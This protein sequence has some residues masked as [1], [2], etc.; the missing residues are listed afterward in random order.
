M[1]QAAN[2]HN[3]SGRNLLIRRH[4]KPNFAASIKK[5]QVVITQ[6][7]SVEFEFLPPFTACLL[8]SL[9]NRSIVDCRE[10]D[11]QERSDASENCWRADS[12]RRKR[13]RKMN[14]HKLRKRRRA[15]RHKR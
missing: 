6:Q 1:D 9:E 3:I 10:D 11:D 2:L 4:F 15:N 14:K 12:V 5:Y 8:R 7:T 13:K